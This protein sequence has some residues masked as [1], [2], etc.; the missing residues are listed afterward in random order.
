MTLTLTGL[1]IMAMLFSQ[2]FLTPD[3]DDLDADLSTYKSHIS[4]VDRVY[5]LAG[6]R[7]FKYVVYT[8]PVHDYTY[9]YLFR[10]YG[11][12]KY[13]YSP[14]DISETAFF[15]IEPDPNQARRQDWI[16]ERK[17]DG[18]IIKEELL[19]NGVIIQE[20]KVD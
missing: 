17:G 13:G 2:I 3:S 18:E 4:I 12:K 11:P 6:E 16:Q 19:R 15:I 20:R 1:T 5:A 9:R 8:P 14:K 7:D 10:W